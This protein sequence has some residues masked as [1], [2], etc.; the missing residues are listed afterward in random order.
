[1]NTLRNRRIAGVVLGLVIAGGLFLLPDD[2][3][4]LIIAGPDI[5]GA[6]PSVIDD[7]PGAVNDHQQGFDERQGVLLAVPLA[8]DG[9]F[10]PAGTLVNSHMIFL[11]TD[12][13]T[14]ATDTATWMFDGLILGVMSDNG[15]T[16]EAASSALL[17]ALGTIYPAA[18]TNRGLE[19]N[20]S[21][22]VAGNILTLID[23]VTEPGDWIRVITQ[24]RS[25]PEPSILL[26]LVISGA[27]LAGTTWLRSH[28][29]T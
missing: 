24:A 3:N 27:G 7:P 6:P 4:A 5:I 18:F 19:A 16:L 23:S 28:R 29:R 26:L 15:G 12:G 11:N 20:D 22:L 9:G 21:Y 13:P 8:V 10:I 2:A 14:F 1:M 17:G 25:V